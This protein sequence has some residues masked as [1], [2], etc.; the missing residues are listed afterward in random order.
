VVML[1]RC[2]VPVLG[3]SPEARLGLAAAGLSRF[4]GL[5]LH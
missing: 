3:L 4:E 1:L 5:Q 2:S